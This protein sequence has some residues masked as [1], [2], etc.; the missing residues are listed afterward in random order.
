MIF[1][2]LNNGNVD[3]VDFSSNIAQFIMVNT[4]EMKVYLEEVFIDKRA[5]N[6]FTTSTSLNTGHF[7]GGKSNNSYTHFNRNQ[8]NTPEDSDYMNGQ[9]LGKTQKDIFKD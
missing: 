9:V 7:S 3:Q 4:G 6:V 1:K 2:K 5:Y 8:N